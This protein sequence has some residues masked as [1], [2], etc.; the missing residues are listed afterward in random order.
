MFLY[1]IV[2]EIYKKHEIQKKILFQNLAD[3]DSTSLFFIFVCKFSCSING[4]TA[5]NIIFEVLTKFKV[6]NRLDLSDKFWEE[7]NVQNKSLKKQ[8]CLYEV[9]NINNANIL[10]IVINP[11]E[12][13][14]K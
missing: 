12:Y 4:K 6:L 14:E 9:E 7:F 3:T 2:K 5:R 10:T 11:R 8:V 13:F 1:D